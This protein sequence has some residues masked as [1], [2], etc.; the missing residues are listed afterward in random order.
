MNKLS[1]YAAL[2]MLVFAVAV[3]ASA[4]D[5]WMEMASCDICRP[6]AEEPELMKNT[7]W[8]HHNISNGLVSVTTVNEDFKRCMARLT[9][10]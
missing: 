9:V 5:R 8:E 2:V 6:M 1:R 10:R 3:S 4:A 7:A